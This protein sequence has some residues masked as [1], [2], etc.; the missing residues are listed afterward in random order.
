M[1][2]KSPCGLARAPE[3]GL[4]HSVQ[5]LVKGS[6]GE[7]ATPV[8]VVP[9]EGRSQACHEMVYLEV[10][11]SP[12][13]VGVEVSREGGEP[14]RY[15]PLPWP[16]LLTYR[17]KIVGQSTKLDLRGSSTTTTERAGVYFP[18]HTC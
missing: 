8:V 15:W 4:Q 12:V 10:A 1:C 17:S 16:R 2:G 9:G 5:V 13:R 18:A 6:G 7:V 11:T 14:S 3:V